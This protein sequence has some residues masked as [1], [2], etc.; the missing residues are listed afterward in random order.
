M[1]RS[2]LVLAL[3]CSTVA[4]SAVAS[5]PSSSSSSSSCHVFPGETLG[6]K[7]IKIISAATAGDCCDACTA[8]PLCAAWTYHSPKVLKLENCFLKDNVKPLVPPRPVDPHNHTMSGLTGG[9]TCVPN[10]KPVELCP[11][12]FPCP[13][14]GAPVCSC[15]S[16]GPVRESPFGCLPPHDTLPFCDQVRKRLFLS[17]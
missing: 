6:Q 9:T 5:S 7:S 15:A 16:K 11:Q 10:A 1:A 12:G 17:L 8:S 2:L 3:A 14:C 4:P 13:D